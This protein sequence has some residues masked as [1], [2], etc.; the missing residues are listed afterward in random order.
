MHTLTANE[1]RTQFGDLLLKVQREPVQISRNGKTVA[2]VVSAEEYQAIESLKLQ[3]L[4]T[5]I[6]R[7]RDDVH[8]GNLADGERFFSSLLEDD[9]S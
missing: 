4:K 3:L 5:K 7:A 9:E 2:V 6:Q 1:A 8:K